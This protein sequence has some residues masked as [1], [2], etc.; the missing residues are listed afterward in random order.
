MAINP[1]TIFDVSVLDAIEKQALLDGWIYL[2]LA[3]AA[4]IGIAIGIYFIRSSLKS[5]EG[6]NE[7]WTLYIGVG[8]ALFCSIFFIVFI[9]MSLGRLLN[10][11]FYAV[12]Y[13]K[14]MLKIQRKLQLPF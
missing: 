9:W 4:L 8:L 7:R 10:P 6:A 12:E 5:E 2:G 1:Y 3:L 13:L 14:G 11:S